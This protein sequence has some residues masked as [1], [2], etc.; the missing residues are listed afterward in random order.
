[1]LETLREAI[2]THRKEKPQVFYTMREAAGHFRVAMSVINRAYKTLESEGLLNSIRGSKTMMEGLRLDRQTAIKAFVGIPVSVSTFLIQQDYRMFF[3]RLS[4]ELQLQ[5]F[6]STLAF[7]QEDDAGKH[8]FCEELLRYRL[9][10]VVW[11]RP[12]AGDNQTAAHLIDKGVRV[13]DVNNVNDETLKLTPRHYFLS[14][15]QAILE[16]LAAWKKEG[17]ESILIARQSP[18]DSLREVF[19]IEHL[20]QKTKLKYSFANLGKGKLKKF[21]KSL[22]EKKHTGIIFPCSRFASLISFRSPEALSGLF[23]AA[24]V[25]LAG[26]PVNMPFIDVPEVTVDLVMIDW[27]LVAERIVE[28]LGSQTVSKTGESRIFEASWLPRVA[29]NQYAQEI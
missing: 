13:I 22:A 3:L 2:L 25:M 23:N 24:R 14:R 15:E 10:A 21:L 11:L 1:M 19:K 16:G 29:L 17:I 4:R 26:G 6:A 8:Q 18:G 20:L 9:D 27:Q 5:G 28:D 12:Q 7:Y